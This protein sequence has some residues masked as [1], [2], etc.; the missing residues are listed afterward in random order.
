PQEDVDADL[1]ASWGIVP[2]WGYALALSSTHPLIPSGSLLWGFWPTSAHSFDLTLSSS[3]LEAENQQPETHFRETSPY[4]ANLMAMYNRYTM[5]VPPFPSSPSST[6]VDLDSDEA[7]QTVL[8]RPVFECGVLLEKYTLRRQRATH[9]LGL[10]AGAPAGSIPGVPAWG[11]RDADLRKAVV[12]S[13][14]AGTKTA[15]S[16]GWMLA[17][18]RGERG[19]LESEGPLGLVQVTSVPGTLAD[20]GDKTKLKVKNVGYGEEELRG[21]VEW[22]RSLEGVE[23]VVMVDFG[24]AK[25]VTEMLVEG[26]KEGEVSSGKQLEMLVLAVGNESKVYS[27]EEIQVRMASGQALGKVQFNTSG[28]RDRAAEVEGATAYFEAVDEAWRRC[29]AEMGLGEVRLERYRGVEGA[30]GIEGAWEALCGQKLAPNAGIV[31]S[32]LMDTMQKDSELVEVAS[33][34]SSSAAADE[35]DVSAAESATPTTMLCKHCLYYDF[36][37]ETLDHE[38]RPIKRA[39]NAVFTTFGKLVDSSA[40]CPLCKLI[41]EGLEYTLARLPQYSSKH[42]VGKDSEIF[43]FMWPR[44]SEGEATIGF[45]I[46]PP[47]EKRFEHRI[48]KAP[49]IAESYLRVYEDME[50]G[51]KAPRN[52]KWYGPFYGDTESEHKGLARSPPLVPWSQSWL[53]RLKQWLN[54]CINE[55][56]ECRMTFSG[57]KVDESLPPV[58]PTRVIDVGPLDGSGGARLMESNGKRGH[59]TALSY[60]WGSSQKS[61][62]PYLTIKHTLE[63]HLSG[64]PWDLLPKT[65]Q[66][67]VLLTRAVGVRYLWIDSLCIIQDSDAD[68][69]EE[70]EKM[71]TVY[72]QARLVIAATTGADAEA[73]LFP[74]QTHIHRPGRPSLYFRKL[75]SERNSPQHSLPL[76]TRGWAMQEWVLARRIVFWTYDRMSW[77]CMRGC[78]GDHGDRV[79]FHSDLTKTSKSWEKIVQLYSSR[80]LTKPGDKLI[81]LRGIVNGIQ[82]KIPEDKYVFGSWQSML[83]WELLWSGQAAPSTDAGL[84]ELHIPSWSWAAHP[85]GVRFLRDAQTKRWQGTVQSSASFLKDL[86]L[87]IMA[88]FKKVDFNEA[89][90]RELYLHWLRNV[91]GDYKFQYISPHYGVSAEEVLAVCSKEIGPGSLQIAFQIRKIAVVFDTTD[92][93]S[94][95]Q[96]ERDNLGMSAGK[97]SFVEIASDMGWDHAVVGLLLRK[98]PQT[99]GRYIRVGLGFAY[100]EWF[101][102]AEIGEF[103][104][105]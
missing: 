68:W 64:I 8:S 71:G 54:D 17:R 23:R 61:A 35:S 34:T 46:I 62:R 88:R 38:F 53:N 80:N 76:F 47:G 77:Y 1:N 49:T 3:F 98:S 21:V 89:D 96:K 78:V 40:T 94:T 44:R 41:L 79:L 72:A 101:G 13:L 42:R 6:Q 67:A 16:F 9:P 91:R 22:V 32:T 59:Y 52:A 51:S 37:Q 104:V 18:E 97:L 19:E 15:R 93:L 11:Q 5:L 56:V 50:L 86:S 90:M 92:F 45:F 43:A 2:A 82:T 66:D 60:C 7:A 31:V 84:Q 81:A 85:G 10:P 75:P 69:K 24:A 63:K 29:Y 25:E 105:D 14:S 99:S 33:S 95:Y 70:A 28:V 4:R 58:L 73:G 48:S 20:F 74:F 55:H 57:E 36:S 30:N 102:D 100:P 26:F 103:I 83:P 87:Q 65:L 39:K 12:I 27:G